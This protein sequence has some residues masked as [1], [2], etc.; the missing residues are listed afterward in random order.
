[1]LDIR[2]IRENP[3]RVKEFTAQKGY[4]A[5]IDELLRLDEQRR[6]LTGR[7]DELRAERNAATT[8]GERPSPEAIDNGKRIKEEIAV[9][10]AEL[11]T[12]D[13]GY[14]TILKQVPNI[15]ESD[16]PVGVSEDE[17]VVAKLVGEPTKFD[18][19]P[20]AHQ[21]IG[22]SRGW[23]DKER[24][25]KV[26]GARF[27]YVKGDLVKLQYSIMQWVTDTLSDEAKLKSIIDGAGLDL[28]AKP[29]EPSLPPAM[30][31]TDAYE[32]TSRLNSEEVTYKLADD[33][34]WLNA[35]AEHSMAPMYM[36]E[37]LDERDLPI[38]YIGFTTAFRR[39]AGTYGKD[40]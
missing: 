32:A 6:R 27:A 13:D 21:A 34:L 12:V 26:A 9:I 5:D 17:N 18:F 14:L 35:S 19:T 25:A 1:M 7:A 11:K 33:E 40:T 4:S 24:A 3:D 10:E 36:N 30:I 38:R 8:K 16:V 23:I 15:P 31:R 22:E 28:S 2:Y 29:F 39:E 20:K 37:I